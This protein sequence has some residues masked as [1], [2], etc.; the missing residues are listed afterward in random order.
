MTKYDE[1]V[2]NKSN[3][4]AQIGIYRSKSMDQIVEWAKELQSLAQAGLFYG[5]DI[6]DKERYQRIR[7][8]SAEMML[9]RADVPAEKI[10]E[11]FC[12]DEGYQTPKV[13]TRAAI[14]KDG[15]ILLVC[16]R[17]KW[18]VP[19]GWCEFNLSPVENI[20]KE[21]KE[22]AGLDVVVKSIIA[23]QDRDKHNSPPY[24]YGVVKIFYLCEAIGGEFTE[25]IETSESRYFSI[26]ELPL[27]AEA[28][29][30]EEQIL[31]CFEAYQANNWTVVFD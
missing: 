31:M 17:G 7:E 20:I 24:A 8:I 10:T 30:N 25:N 23:V 12:G 11:L 29:C 16:E 18:S 21:T 5:H 13:D 9:M 28:K 4:I 1:A 6:Y 22:E 14:F 15:K 19:G 2:Y 3:I 26:E 27:L